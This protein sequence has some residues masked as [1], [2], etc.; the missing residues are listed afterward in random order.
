MDRIYV[1]CGFLQ[2]SFEARDCPDYFK[3]ICV[4]TEIV[5][6]QKFRAIAAHPGFHFDKVRHETGNVALQYGRIA[7]DH[8]LGHHFGFVVLIHDCVSVVKHK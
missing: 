7:F 1:V 8:I 5:H 2:H 6:R 4:C 3:N